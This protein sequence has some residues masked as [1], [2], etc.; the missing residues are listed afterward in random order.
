[1]K[2]SSYQDYVNII[3]SNY[4]DNPIDIDIAFFG[5]C[6][7]QPTAWDYVL[8]SIRKYY[9]TEQIVLINDGMEQFDYTDMAKKYNCII[10]NK[11]EEICLFWPDIKSSY[12]YLHRVKE[13]CDIVKTEWLIHLHPDVICQGRISYPPNA[14]L[15][16]VVNI[17]NIN[18]FD[19]QSGNK[20]TGDYWEQVN[21]FI[22]K[23]NTETEVE[24]NG[25]GWC[26]GSIMNVS[27]YY[28]VYNSIFG[29]N[30]IDWIK[31]LDENIKTAREH[32]DTLFSILFNLNGFRYRVWKDNPQYYNC[33]V[34]G[35]FL[36]GYKEHY[37][38]KKQ[39]LTTSEYFIKCK[40]EI[41]EKRN[42]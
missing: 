17:E 35:A 7:Y 37:D 33:P 18:N 11:K 4:E 26:G 30:G 10:L 14:E 20:W 9:K 13:V 24:L 12:E 16:G 28:Q 2:I 15:A 8:E 29:E 23:Y 5:L 21:D 38:F 34:K 41:N 22:K 3:K 27:A 25:W 42:I 36:H 1:M 19:G 6:S 31:Y 32:E 39:N 40:K